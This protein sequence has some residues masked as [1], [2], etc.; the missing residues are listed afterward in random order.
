MTDKTSD[1]SR[2]LLTRLK[3]LVEIV[4]TMQYQIKAFHKVEDAEFRSDCSRELGR[5]KTRL[6]NFTLED[7][8]EALET[9]N[10]FYELSEAE[11]TVWDKNI[12]GNNLGSCMWEY[13]KPYHLQ[14]EEVKIF[15]SNLLIK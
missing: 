3:E 4:K 13:G 9:D 2:E 6:L 11:L 7:V 8:L 1:R 5:A 10:M 15:I 12:G 14:S